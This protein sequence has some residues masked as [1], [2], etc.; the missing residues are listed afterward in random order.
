MTVHDVD[1]RR[2]LVFALL[3]GAPAFAPG[4]SRVPARTPRRF[5]PSRRSTSPACARD[6]TLDALA[7]RARDAA[8]DRSAPHDLRAGRAVARRNAPRLRPSWRAVEAASRKSWPPARS[9]SSSWPRRRLRR[10]PHELSAGRADP[11]GPWRPSSSSR[12]RSRRSATRSNSSLAASPG[13]SSFGRRTIRSGRSI[14]PASTTN[15]RIA[16]TRSPSSSTAATRTRTASSSSRSCGASGE[17]ARDGPTLTWRLLD[18]E[19]SSV[20]SRIGALEAG[21]SVFMKPA[22]DL[23]H[24]AEGI[25]DRCDASDDARSTRRR[26][27]S[28]RPRR[29]SGDYNEGRSSKFLYSRYAN[30]T[31]ARG[32]AD[33]RRARRRRI[34]A[35]AVERS[36]RD[37][38]RAR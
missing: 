15:G 17:P 29:R 31:V 34:G 8:G 28:S 14:S 20:E 38:D 30:P 36:G 1:A 16:R 12:S 23:I 2:D 7:A 13:C 27:S 19:R 33:D 4:S 32:R 11:R 21:T 26:R 35:R 10:W 25:S 18:R 37:D 24:V 3:H 9:R 5:V 6:H 22:T